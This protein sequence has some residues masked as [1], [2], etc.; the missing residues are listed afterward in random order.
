MLK[1][2]LIGGYISV[3]GLFEKLAPNG[4]VIVRVGSRTYEGKPV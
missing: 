2:I 1:T 4:N 3:Q